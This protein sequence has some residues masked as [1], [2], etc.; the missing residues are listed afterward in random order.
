MES[1]IAALDLSK[2][3]VEARLRVAS[4]EPAESLMYIDEEDI[5]TVRNY[6]PT[7]TTSNHL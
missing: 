4:M 7:P 3:E 6:P 5:G 2:E 1:L